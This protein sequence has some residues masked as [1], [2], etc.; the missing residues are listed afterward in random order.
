MCG[1]ILF[2]SFVLT[3]YIKGVKVLCVDLEALYLV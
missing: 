1:D 2:G 3:K